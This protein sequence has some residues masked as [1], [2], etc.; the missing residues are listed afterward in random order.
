MRLTLTNFR[1]TDEAD[2]QRALIEMHGLYCLSRPSKC[3]ALNITHIFNYV[4]IFQ[5]VSLLQRQNLKHRHCLLLTSLKCS[6]H[7]LSPLVAPNGQ[8]SLLLSQFPCQQLHRL[9]ACRYPLPPLDPILPSLDRTMNHLWGTPTPTPVSTPVTHCAL[10]QV[11]AR[12][13][14]YQLRSVDR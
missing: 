11:P 4:L 10:N 7:P 6:S 9:K 3:C 12:A 8:A 14:A 1:F 13:L 2:Q 5:C